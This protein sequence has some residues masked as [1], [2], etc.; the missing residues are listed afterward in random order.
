[1]M[2]TQFRILYPQ[3]GVISELVTIDHGKYIVRVLIKVGSITLGTGLAGANTIEEAEDAARNRALGL[4]KLDSISWNPNNLNTSQTQENHNSGTIATKVKTNESS[5]SSKVPNISVVAQTHSETLLSE[6]QVPVATSVKVPQTSILEASSSK[7]SAFIETTTSKSSVQ[8]LSVSSIN[9]IVTEPVEK[10]FFKPSLVEEN[11]TSP[12]E[13]LAELMEEVSPRSSQVQETFI[14]TPEIG[15]I[16]TPTTIISQELPDVSSSK[17]QSHLTTI[18][19]PLE[20][21]EII[22]RS[23]VEMKRLGWT[24][25]QGREYLIQT[26]GKRS[27]QVLSDEELLEFLDYLQSLP[28]PSQT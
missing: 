14:S 12:N 9:E 2:L 4:L 20:F 22:A 27:R 11:S 3:G 15:K 23:N 28:T 1:M 17:D 16:S 10:V 25:V 8:V 21:S 5:F 26:Y 24:K 7:P 18:E 6:Q 13:K 19:E